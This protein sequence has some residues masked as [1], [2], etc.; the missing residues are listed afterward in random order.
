MN[1]INNVALTGS[2]GGLFSDNTSVVVNQATSHFVSNSAPLGYGGGLFV[3]HPAGVATIYR[4]ARVKK[5]KNKTE[6]SRIATH[7]VKISHPTHL[8]SSVKRRL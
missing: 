5:K 2:G 1:F 6:G 8:S 7:F 3:E 4:Y